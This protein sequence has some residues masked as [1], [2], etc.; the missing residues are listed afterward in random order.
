MIKEN[1]LEC[2]FVYQKSTWL[3]ISPSLKICQERAI[4]CTGKIKGTFKQASPSSIT[5]Q[6]GVEDATLRILVLP[7]MRFRFPLR[8]STLSH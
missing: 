8:C 7:V 6:E 2:L 5:H 3:W 1:A 4:L